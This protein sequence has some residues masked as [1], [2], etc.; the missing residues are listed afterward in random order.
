MVETWTSG[1]LISV[2][3]NSST[4][5][6]NFRN[7]KNT[8]LDVN[9]DTKNHDNAQLLSYVFDVIINEV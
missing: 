7:Y 8:V 4:T 1:N 9:E 2:V 5:L 3:S 6:A